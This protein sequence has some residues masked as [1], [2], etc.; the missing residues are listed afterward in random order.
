[1]SEARQT[2]DTLFTTLKVCFFVNALL[3]VLVFLLPVLTVISSG[4]P[5]NTILISFKILQYLSL[6][7]IVLWIYCFYFYFKY[8][9]Y[10]SSGIR[11][12][13]LNCFYTPFYFYKVIWKRKRELQNTFQSEQVIGNRIHLETEEENE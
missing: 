9:R 1:M 6:P 10:S 5:E 3:I 2:S 11:L 4:L 13:V 7:A 12:L 8:D